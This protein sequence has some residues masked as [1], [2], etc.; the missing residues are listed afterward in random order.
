MW[1]SQR[2]EAINKRMSE[3]LRIKNFGPIKEMSFEF[4]KINILIGEQS[5]GKSAVVKL[6]AAINRMVSEEITI[7]GSTI[8]KKEGWGGLTDFKQHLRSFAIDNYLTNS[9]EINYSHTFFQF[10]FSRGNSVIDKFDTSDQ[11]DITF[12][13]HLNTTFIPADRVV[14][15]LLSPEIF[16]SLLETKQ[17]LPGYLLRF[18]QE[19]NKAK[20]DS[21]KYDFTK[22]L[23]VKYK[24]ENEID[25][26]EITTGQNINLAEA[27][28]AIQTNIPL[29]II[30][31]HQSERGIWYSAS[32]RIPELNLIVIEEP[33]L[34][35]FPTLQKAMLNYIVNCIHPFNDTYLQRCIITT[36]SPYILTSL[37]NLMYAYEVGS[38]EP[39]KTD[40]IISKK[41]WVNPHDVAAYRLIQGGTCRDI[42]ETT[43]DGTLI[44]ASEIDEVSSELNSEFDELIRLEIAN[45]E[46]K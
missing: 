30:I 41:Y 16:Y 37:N 3:T 18:G 23:G 34:N 42:V 44:E 4:K 40:A 28:S 36:H 20:K 17:S 35:C 38:R 12:F 19:Y 22:T 1:R 15:T 45:T 46:V 11:R 13:Q 25:R 10:T 29:M 5:T 32:P 21:V 14:V 33:E 9:T 31:E 8:T 6:L 24:Y 2:K 7:Y 39:E 27:S 43:E 26:I